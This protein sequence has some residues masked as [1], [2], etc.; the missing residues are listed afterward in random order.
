MIIDILSS[1]SILLCMLV[2]IVY[3]KYKQQLKRAN[4]WRND[5]IACKQAL[6][7]KNERFKTLQR[8]CE[9]NCN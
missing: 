4:S 8:Y 2:Y 9:E 5:Y 3:N 7:E 6:D 1:I